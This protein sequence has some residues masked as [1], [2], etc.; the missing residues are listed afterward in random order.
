MFQSFSS[1]RSQEWHY[2]PGLRSQGDIVS[3]LPVSSLHC[4]QSNSYE[5]QIWSCPSLARAPHLPFRSGT[6]S[7]PALPP[8]PAFSPPPHAS[9]SVYS[10]PLGLP[11]ASLTGRSWC[12][13]SPTLCTLFFLSRTAPSPHPSYQE[14]PNRFP[15]S[16]THWDLSSPAR[17][18]V[19]IPAPPLTNLG[20][21]WNFSELS[22]LMYKMKMLIMPASFAY[23]EG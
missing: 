4:C 16:S 18:L 13:V 19:W 21:A 12:I 20:K 3:C 23:H 11:P 22:F 5:M 9:P 10:A 7:A 15:R 8:L 14:A 1:L 6:F 17:S 2:L